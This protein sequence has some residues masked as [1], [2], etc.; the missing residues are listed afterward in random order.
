MGLGVVPVALPGALASGRPAEGL[1]ALASALGPD[2]N[3][4]LAAPLLE[5]AEDGGEAPGVL[6]PAPRT[7][8][9]LQG[10]GGVSRGAWLT[11]WRKSAM[12]RE[13]NLLRL[14]VLPEREV[15]APERDAQPRQPSAVR[16]AAGLSGAQALLQDRERFGVTRRFGEKIAELVLPLETVGMGRA[17]SLG[18]DPTRFSEQGLGTLQVASQ[19][20]GLRQASGTGGGACMGVSSAQ[21]QRLFQKRNGPID[22]RARQGDEPEVA[23]RSARPSGAGRRTPF[24]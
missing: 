4:A 21:A 19:S 18:A 12:R 20:N 9:V 17:E 3:S 5:I 14:L 13:E 10:P 6:E 2:G 23:A 8:E 16:D 22:V 1:P 15:A 7:V 11:P 24:D